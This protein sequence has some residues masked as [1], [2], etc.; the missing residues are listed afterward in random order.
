MLPR[1]VS[2]ALL[3]LLVGAAFLAEATF[4]DV[5]TRPTHTDLGFREH[6][7]ARKTTVNA[8]V[9]YEVTTVRYRSQALPLVQGQI[10]FTNP[11]RTPMPMPGGDYAILGFVGEVVD[12]RNVSVPLSTV[13]DHHW[14]AVD[15][16]HRN[17]L[18][19]WDEYST[20]PEYVFGIGAE[21]RKTPVRF[22]EGYGYHI[23]DGDYFGGNIHLLHTVDLEGDDGTPEGAAAAA[24][25]CNE[26]YYAPG[27]GAACT[28]AMN[29]TFQCCGDRCFDG[30]CKCPTK[31]GTKLVPTDFYLSY[32]VTFTRNIS[33][34]KPVGVG[35]Y[36]TPNCQLYY[37]VLRNDDE[38]INISRTTFTV[39]ADVEVLL[40]IGHQHVGAINTSL[41]H[42]GKTV[43]TS[44]PTYGTETGVAGD[45]KGYLVKMSPC[46][47]KG[48]QGAAPLK[49]KK[50]DTVTVEGL[51]YVGSDDNRL[52][53]SDGTHLNVMTYMY[54]AYSLD[55]PTS[56]SA[57]PVGADCAAALKRKCAPVIGYQGQCDDCATA[58]KQALGAAGC[59]EKGVIQACKNRWFV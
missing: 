6:V 14:I 13:Y 30:S 49:F 47:Q 34:I 8:E 53:F 7:E 45:E 39:P 54:I 29:G 35:V 22:P 17:Q 52:L 57:P 43:C 33:M 37:A 4:L 9:G 50:G 59:T 24:K 32:T 48:Q 42:N 56:P 55:T 12:S 41:I 27:K 1:L 18:C 16:F 44:F 2:S 46:F 20:G 15:T 58:N 11:G 36:T 31:A 28:P 19:N 21:S 5:A 26:C 38:P 51:Y 23:Y 10:V 40:A 3:L 25:H